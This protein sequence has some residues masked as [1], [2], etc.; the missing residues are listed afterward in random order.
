GVSWQLYDALREIEDNWHVKMTYDRGQLELTPPS[1]KQSLRPIGRLIGTLTDELNIPL[2]SLRATTW[3]R[4][5][6]EFALEADECYYIKCEPAIRAE[7]E[8]DG[9][10]DPPPDLAIE[11]EV[12]RKAINKMSLY[13]ML[14][15]AEV[16][17]FD[18]D[19]LQA[20]QLMSDGKYTECDRS[21]NLPF[22]SIADLSHFLR[23][24]NDVGETAWIRS[25][26]DWV[27][28]TYGDKQVP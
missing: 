16:W 20:F 4:K 13:A 28:E 23:P 19:R 11:S 12:S 15:V 8:I 7:P 1:G 24:H 5:Q 9:A 21:V 26:R 6:Q 22:L 2:R 25:F 10:S 17:R 14:G 27:R 3:K 18:G